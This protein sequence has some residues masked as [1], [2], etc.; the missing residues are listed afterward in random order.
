MSKLQP[1]FS[2]RLRMQHWKLKPTPSWLSALGTSNRKWPATER[3][4]GKLKLKWTA[5]WRYSEKWRM[6]KMT[7]TKRSMSWRGGF[8]D[9]VSVHVYMWWIF[10]GG[11]TI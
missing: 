2:I 1:L 7:K 4:L 5:S 6:R 11:C 8:V 10:K 9:L 3:I